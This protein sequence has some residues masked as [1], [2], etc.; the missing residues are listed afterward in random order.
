MGASKQGSIS[1]VVNVLDEEENM[2]IHI[3]RATLYEWAPINITANALRAD[4]GRWLG[5]QRSLS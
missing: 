5:C 1:V 2:D 3:T 4:Q